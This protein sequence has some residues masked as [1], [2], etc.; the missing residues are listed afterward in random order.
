M[1]IYRIKG[2]GEYESPFWASD[3][4]E[5][6]D[7]SFWAERD[8]HDLQSRRKKAS[9]WK[10]I[11]LKFN[12]VSSD[13][14]IRDIDFNLPDSINI[15]SLKQGLEMIVSDT[16]K[17][18][19]YPYIKHECAFLPVD[20]VD[21]SSEYWV[22]YVTNILDCLDIRNSKFGRYKPKRI[23]KYAFEV[24]KIS[25][26]YLFRLPGHYDYLVDRDFA[27]QLFLNLVQDLELRGFEFW[28]CNNLGQEPIVT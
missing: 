4:E 25:K 19:L 24:N 22:L 23:R 14:Q 9:D 7:G 3:E 21:I 12:S 2:D 8:N 10:K 5:K 6:D 11:K 15:F 18:K 27:S 16:A 28:E 20:L 13:K 17:Q 1:R 26:T